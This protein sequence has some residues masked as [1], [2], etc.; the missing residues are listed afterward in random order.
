VDTRG[1]ESTKQDSFGLIVNNLWF[2]QWR[3]AIQTVLSEFV[4][5]ILVWTKCL[6]P[7]MEKMSIVIERRGREANSSQLL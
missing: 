5:L 3:G 6:T 4:G 2:L 1:R 7:G